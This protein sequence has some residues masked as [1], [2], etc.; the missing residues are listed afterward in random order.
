MLQ[1]QLKNR[2]K[3]RS[4]QTQW[5]AACI[6]PYPIKMSSWSRFKSLQRLIFKEFTKTIKEIL[7]PF[8]GVNIPGAIFQ[9]WSFTK[10]NQT[11]HMHT[12]SFLPLWSGNSK[13]SFGSRNP[14]KTEKSSIKCTQN[15]LSHKTLNS[16][17][18]RLQKIIRTAKGTVSEIWL[19][20]V[21]P[22]CPTTGNTHTAWV[23]WHVA[24]YSTLTFSPC[25]LSCLATGTKNL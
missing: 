19:S 4:S 6:S 7:P 8:K 18:T 16:A 13:M 2:V 21:L 12:I 9:R 5:R 20:W 24:I 15:F 10:N 3:S 22:V 25:R 17:R 14:S 11:T 23:L 1:E